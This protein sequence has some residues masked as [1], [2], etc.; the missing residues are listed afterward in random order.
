MSNTAL[1][2]RRA[3]FAVIPMLMAG[4]AI[5]QSPMSPTA[6]P[7]A[8]P[9]SGA[10]MV[11]PAADMQAVLDAM[12]SM[13]PLPSRKSRPPSPASSRARPMARAR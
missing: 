6:P 8:F 11:K 13:N 9:P 7:P 2:V 12:A 4:T 3:A 5:A 1:F 10:P